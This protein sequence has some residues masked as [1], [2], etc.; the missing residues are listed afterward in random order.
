MNLS[1]TKNVYYNT[2]QLICQLI[3]ESLKNNCFNNRGL[4][5]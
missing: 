5:V 2:Y 1:G 4:N 3:S